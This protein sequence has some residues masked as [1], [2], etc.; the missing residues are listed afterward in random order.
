MLLFLGGKAIIKRVAMRRGT[1]GNEYYQHISTEGFRRETNSAGGKGPTLFLYSR[2][3][4]MV[5]IAML[6]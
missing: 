6:Q 1:F 4:N 3:W 2:R 5:A